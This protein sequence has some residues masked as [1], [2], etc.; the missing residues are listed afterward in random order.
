[1][2]HF[3]HDKWAEQKKA[4]DWCL[5]YEMDDDYIYQNFQHFRMFYVC[6][7]WCYVK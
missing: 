2:N 4:G 6:F 1:M 5:C 3:K 7:A